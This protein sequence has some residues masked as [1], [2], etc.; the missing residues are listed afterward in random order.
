MCKCDECRGRLVI[1]IKGA[2]GVRWRKRSAAIFYSIFLM[3][4][5]GS[6]SLETG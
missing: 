6:S 1:D 5:G 4:K 2:N 3:C